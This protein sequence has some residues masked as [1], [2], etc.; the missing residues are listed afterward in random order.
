MPQ[1]DT[2]YRIQYVNK[3]RVG[4]DDY[5]LK[6][7]VMNIHHGDLLALRNSGELCGWYR[8]T[9]YMTLTTQEDTQSAG[10]HFDIIVHADDPETLNE[11]AYAI[12]RSNDEY[13]T[14]NGS[15]LAAW[16]LKYC[17]DNDTHRFAWADPVNGKGVIYYM[18]DEF[19]NECP[20]DFKNIMFKRTITLES[21]YP[22]LDLEGGEDTWC[23]TFTATKYDIANDAWSGIIDGSLESPYEHMSDENTST[24]HHNVIKEYIPVYNDDEDRSKAGLMYLNNNV[25]LGYFEY[26]DGEDGY[27]YAYCS[28]SNNFGNNCYNNTFGNKCYGNTFGDECANNTFWNN[29]YGNTFRTYCSNNTFRNCGNNTFR[30]TCNDN[31]FGNTCND[32]T[33]GNGCSGNTFGN[34][35]SGNTFGN[36][37]RNNTFGSACYENTFGNDCS[38]ITFGSSG[39]PQSYCNNFIFESGNR[40]I[41]LVC[42]QTTSG[43][44]PCRNILV[45]LG[46]NNSNTNKTITITEVNQTHKTI[47]KTAND[48]E[49]TA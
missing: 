44:T 23:Y 24:Y 20:Y 10:H 9:D 36:D 28:Y 47:V 43:S 33:F 11:N 35:C 12:P 29:C 27:Q 42:N 5:E 30:N 15:N 3:V 48:V 4:A 32:N 2:I 25:F 31:T 34:G 37:C 21:G 19:G 14:S 16:E 39:T 45:S 17:L 41:N 22:E 46:V 38:S 40:N 49:I 6:E 7:G 18:K 8:I 1:T 13:F 26:N